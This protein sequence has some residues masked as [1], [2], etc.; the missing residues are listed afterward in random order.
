[1]LSNYC[2][3]SSRGIRVQ[4]TKRKRHKS[5]G[6]KKAMQKEQPAPRS[7]EERW[8]E[9]SPQLSVVMREGTIPEVVPFDATLEVPIEDQKVEAMKKIQKLLRTKFLEQAIGLIRSSSCS[10]SEVFP[11]VVALTT[12]AF[13][14]E[15]RSKP[16][17][18]RARQ[19]N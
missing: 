14:L 3:K 7:L 8:D 12:A 5:S 6:K 9:I 11:G 4:E 13:R 1:M 17:E 2:G 10:L 16:N 19:H 15:I 18:A